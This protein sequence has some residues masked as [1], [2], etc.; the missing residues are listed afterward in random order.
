MRGEGRRAGHPS[1]ME[2]SEVSEWG[3]PVHQV[4]GPLSR[5]DYRR[6]DQSSSKD[7]L[8]ED[9]RCAD[10]DERERRGRG[11]SVS[12]NKGAGSGNN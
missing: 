7:L 4:T 12:G 2:L 5:P 3:V 9:G 10:T 11:I 6:M 8:K 1:L